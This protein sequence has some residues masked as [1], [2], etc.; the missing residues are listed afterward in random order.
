MREIEIKHLAYLLKQAKINQQ[1]QPIF[2]LGAGASTSGNIPLAGEIVTHI[3]R[4]YVDSP[5]INELPSDQRSYA[6]LMNCLSPNQRDE[7]LKKYINEA[8][9]NV[10]HIYLAQIL[11]EGYADYILTVNFD[12]LMI[13][14]LALFNIF[15]STYDMAIL[16]DL[17][18]STFIEKSIVYLH[19]Q[20]HG[21][22]LL[23]T[24][25]EMEKVKNTVPRIFDTIKNRRPWVFIGYS[26]E[27]PIFEYIKNLGRFDNGLYWVTHN[28]NNPNDNVKNF[29]AKSNTNAFLIKGYDS[30]SFMLKLNS[31]LGLG[32]P[33]IVDKPFSALK[34][35]LTEIV[36]IDDKEHFKGVKQRLE[37]SKSQVDEAILHFEIGSVDLSKDAEKNKIDILKKEIINLIVS[38]KYDDKNISVIEK[39]VEV[40]D[41]DNLNTLLS[42][43]NS[44]WGTYLGDLAKT[45]EGKDAEVLYF[46]AFE[47][48]QK[49]IDIN[50]DHNVAFYNWGTYLGNLAE[51]KDGKEAE[52]LY[53]QAF[54]KYQKAIEI[55]PEYYQTFY[56]WGTYLGDLAKIKKAK[57][58]RHCICKPLKNSKA[59]DI[60]PENKNSYYNWGTYLGNLAET[61]EGKEAEAL[62]MQA[63]EKYQ[64]A[65]D[66]QPDKD[67][68]FNNWGINLGNLAKTKKG[69]DAEAL[70]IQAFEKFQKAIDIK[71]ENNVAFYN[72]GT[73]LGNL[74]QIKEGQEA[75]ALYM[76]SFEKFKIQPT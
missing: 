56:N 14:A 34:I 25:E 61:K 52:A 57:M 63:F 67:D 47:K 28:D 20:S 30:D 58:Q 17:T 62:Y 48:F 1:P 45:K 76:Q 12:N 8:K 69:I 53:I 75:E 23:N 29:I 27:D 6:N 15:P 38:E 44:N 35:M 36:D 21:L 64:K 19:G 59:I 11:N 3:L 55:N 13:R 4:N 66:I 72:W 39:R 24:L 60:N 16:K 5:F 51:I 18:T 22:W 50:P 73:Y 32:Q 68:V 26:G 31:E 49:A 74:A 41:D 40:I 70:H 7:L 43:F 54:E 65:L 46:Q 71:P 9:I 42:D 10:T 33:N 37:I 2:F